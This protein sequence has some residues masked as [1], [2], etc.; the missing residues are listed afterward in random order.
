MRS[1]GAS[2]PSAT[3]AGGCSSSA[4]AAAPATPRTRSTTSAS[5]AHIESYAPSDNV[6][7]LTARTNDD[8]WETAYAAWLR[9]SRLGDRD[10]V[11]VFSVGGG[12]REHNVSVNLVNAIELAREVGAAIYG[13]VGSPDGDDGELADV[14]SSS[15]PP[16]E[17][18]HAARRVVPGGRL[19]RC[20]SRTRSSR[21]RRQVGV[22]RG[23]GDARRAVF[24]DRDGVLNEL[25]PDPVRAARVAAPPARTSRSS[26]ARPPALAGCATPAIALVGVSNQPAAAKGDVD[27]DAAAEPCTSASLELLAL[28]GA[29]STLRA[30]LPSP[31]RHRARAQRD[32]RVPQAGARDA[33]RRRRRARLDLAAILDGRRHRRGRR[34][35]GGRRGAARSWSSTRRART[36]AAERR[37]PRTR[38][39]RDLARGRRGSSRATDPRKLPR[40]ARAAVTV[41][42]FAD[43]ADLD[44]ILRS[45]ERPPHRGL[46]DEPDA[47]VEGRADRLRR[48]RAAAARADHEAPDLLRGV[49]R[50]R[51]RDAP[52][53]AADRRLG[54]RTSTSRSRSRRPPASRWRRSCASSPRTACRST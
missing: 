23:R 45:A 9:G 3:E 12:S 51:G 50:R 11:L 32:L 2:R 40:R 30:L 24:L 39:A 15:S 33:A 5:S 7:E 46:H 34:R 54:R 31:G 20:S 21:R 16:A 37:G 38:L 8:G 22:D 47:D 17:L 35:R 25:V 49:R 6:S 42:I 52:P 29:A 18:P 41:K 13:I 28:E 4:S 26:P 53:G 48:L 14:A 27:V 44:G 10:A 19:A 1:R 43:G 36:S